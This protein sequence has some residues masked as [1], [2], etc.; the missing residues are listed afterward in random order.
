MESL[1]SETK[2]EEPNEAERV[3]RAPR[4]PW[5][6]IVRRVSKYA[7]LAILFL[8]S[9]ATIFGWA[10]SSKKE[11]SLTAAYGSS[12]IFLFTSR[13]GGVWFGDFLL[14][15]PLVL[16]YTPP[17]GLEFQSYD[18]EYDR[19]ILKITP[20]LTKLGAGIVYKIELFD[21]QGWQTGPPTASGTL[22]ALAT[23]EVTLDGL[24]IILPH[25]MLLFILI[26]LFIFIAMGRRFTLR[27]FLIWV[28]MAC[29]SLG[30]A[31]R[32]AEWDGG[33]G[34]GGT[35]NLKAKQ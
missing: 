30:I 3:V 28:T 32:T 29:V 6:V 20:P 34:Q 18:R 8:A 33:G 1:E 11:H 27:M 12:R 31:L 17:S 16:G 14:T 24:G 21:S 23:P 35:W 7:S 9:C 2:I 4:P 19:D 10:T 13:H 26:S 5:R 22:M 15:V 25:W